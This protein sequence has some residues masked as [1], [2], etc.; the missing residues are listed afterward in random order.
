MRQEDTWDHE[1][2]QRY[3]TP[4]TGM[5]APRGSSGRLWTGSLNSPVTAARRSS[6]P[7]PAA[8]RSPGSARR[9]CRG[10]R[11]IRSDDRAATHQGRRDDH[12]GDCRRHGDPGPWPRRDLILLHDRRR[13]R[14]LDALVL[15]EAALS[16]RPSRAAS[17]GADE[18]EAAA[19]EV[20]ILEPG[21]E[22]GFRRG[23]HHS[24]GDQRSCHGCNAEP[25][26]LR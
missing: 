21:L 13:G 20:R 1:A 3:D 12:P 25:V 26:E 19:Q 9:A 5:L 10:H 15:P 18:R 7:A 4:G 14:V 2:A 6:P 24:R 23:G 16:G 8:S 17:P 11:A 22:P